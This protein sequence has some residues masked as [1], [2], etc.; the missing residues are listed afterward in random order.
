MAIT[1]TCYSAQWTK[2]NAYALSGATGGDNTYRQLGADLHARKRI[3]FFKHTLAA[4]AGTGS[5]IGFVPKLR[6]CRILGIKLAWSALGTGAALDIIGTTVG[7][8]ANAL[9][10]ASTAGYTFG[11]ALDVSAAGSTNVA[12]TIA[13]NYGAEIGSAGMALVGYVTAITLGTGT[14]I[15]GQIDYVE[16]NT[17]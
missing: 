5:M 15:S 16:Y 9:T 4:T 1:A 12:A 13:Q 7:E 6:D 14:I 17:F 8:A 10:T 2:Y 3:A 11:A